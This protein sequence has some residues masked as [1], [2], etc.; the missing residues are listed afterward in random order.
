MENWKSRRRVWNGRVAASL[1]QAQ[2][3]DIFAK[4]PL[5]QGVGSYCLKVWMQQT[6]LSG[7]VKNPMF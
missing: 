5:D 7:E 1:S 4:Y 3:L 2:K 6:C